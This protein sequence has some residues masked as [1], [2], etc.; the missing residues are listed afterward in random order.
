MVWGHIWWG[1]IATKL[2]EWG[3]FPKEKNMKKYRWWIL[4]SLILIFSMVRFVNP[5]IQWFNHIG[6]YRY[7]SNNT[8]EVASSKEDLEAREKYD[9]D[10]A[11]YQKDKF[12]YDDMMGVVRLK[13]IKKAAD[14][15]AQGAS[16]EEIEQ[17]VEEDAEDS[18]GTWMFHPP[19]KPRLPEAI[20]RYEVFTNQPILRGVK[21]LPMFVTEIDRCEIIY[22]KDPA[23]LSKKVARVVVA[24]NTSGDDR[25]VFRH[26]EV[27]VWA[28]TQNVVPAEPRPSVCQYSR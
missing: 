6:Y 9:A 8:V 28:E 2:T 23:L 1:I 4:G 5:A 13:A 19:V 26:D 14:L 18:N 25:N 3:I 11:Q 27:T 24:A 12:N 20:T 17:D 21:V 7:I 22:S 10:M 15:K 16:K